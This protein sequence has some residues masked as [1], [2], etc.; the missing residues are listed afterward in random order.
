MKLFG[1]QIV[2]ADEADTLVPSAL[3]WTLI[4]FF[5]IFGI[6]NPD[7]RHVPSAALLL[8]HFWSLD[9]YGFLQNGHGIGGAIGA[10][11]LLTAGFLIFGWHRGQAH[12]LAL[13]RT[14][15][16]IAFVVALTLLSVRF[17]LDFEVFGL[18]TTV[19]DAGGGFFIKDLVLMAITSSVL[20]IAEL[21]E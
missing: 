2:T 11:E 6:V 7:W 17:Q 3:R 16:L 20:A 10:I 18:N 21:W 19:H 15:T 8:T 14:V 12:S 4:G 13:A 1:Y 9:T 5:V